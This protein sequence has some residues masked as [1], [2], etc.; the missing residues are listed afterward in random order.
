MSDVDESSTTLAVPATGEVVLLLDV[1]G[2]WIVGDADGVV[3]VVVRSASPSGFRTN[4]MVQLTTVPAVTTLDDLAAAAA[5][6][7]DATHDAVEARGERPVC[8]GDAAGVVRL[9]CFDLGPSA[10]RLAQLQLVVDA[11]L[12][13]AGRTVFT[14]AVTCAADDLPELGDELA[15]LVSGA[16]LV[17]SDDQP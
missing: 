2:G 7:F 6:R 9:V 16:L 1:P 12:S 8:V 5:E 3:A 4:A 15:S 11:G 13:G 17:R 14:V 10:A